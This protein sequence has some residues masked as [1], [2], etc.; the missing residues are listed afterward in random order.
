MTTVS[1]TASIDS[2]RDDKVVTAASALRRQI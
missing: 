2:L 1:F